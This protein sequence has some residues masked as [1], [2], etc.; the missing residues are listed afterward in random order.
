MREPAGSIMR[1]RRRCSTP[2][3]APR[4]PISRLRC[5]ATPDGRIATKALGAR[6]ALNPHN[7]VFGYVLGDDPK[8]PPVEAEYV[9]LDFAM[10]LGWGG[11]WEGDGAQAMGAAPFPPGMIEAIDT[12]SLGGMLDRIESITDATIAG[13][14]NRIPD[15]Y[16]P[17]AQREVIA[18]GIFSAA[19]LFAGWLPLQR[20]GLMKYLAASDDPLIPPTKISRPL[21]SMKIDGLIPSTQVGGP[22]RRRS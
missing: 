14:V 16:L 8:Q 1:A 19:I 12:I 2:R 9:F 22:N 20:G 10:A 15:D 11:L 6:L 4:R 13:I 5:F 21:P 18:S 3:T 7:I 17:A